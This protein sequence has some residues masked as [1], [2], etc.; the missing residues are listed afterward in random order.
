MALAAALEQNTALRQLHLQ[1]NEIGGAGAAHI[2]RALATNTALASLNL[3]G[4]PIGDA[5]GI[6]LA[7][8]LTP[9]HTPRQTRVTS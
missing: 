3:G 5:G 6:A 1:D 2:A 8:A 4:N 7:D 9:A